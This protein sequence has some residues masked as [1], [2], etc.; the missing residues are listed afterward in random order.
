MILI[1][2]FHICI[3]VYNNMEYIVHG[4]K[5]WL[6]CMTLTYFGAYL[7]ET[8][9]SKRCTFHK[10]MLQSKLISYNI[11]YLFAQSLAASLLH[12]LT[13]HNRHHNHVHICTDAHKHTFIYI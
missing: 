9:G 4:S 1:M 10:V 12:S 2:T 8:D 13:S 3:T 7:C 6:C 5:I 11:K